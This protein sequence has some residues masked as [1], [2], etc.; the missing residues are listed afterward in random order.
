M[1]GSLFGGNSQK[2][3]IAASFLSIKV[4]FAIPPCTRHPASSVIPDPPHYMERIAISLAGH[5]NL[6]KTTLART[7]LREDI[8]VVDDRPHVTDVADGRVIEKDD[9]A[10]IILWDLPG[11][12]DSVR[13][14]QRLVK[15]GVIAWLMTVYDRW[16]DRP[17][18]CSQKCIENAKND[19]DVV[20]YLVDANADPSSSPEVCAEMDVLGL[21]G[22]PVII[23]LNQTG[24]PDQRRDGQLSS[25]WRRAMRDYPFVHDAMPMDGW[26]RCWIHENMLFARIAPLLTD[27]KRVHYERLIA[28]WKTRH[29]DDVFEEATAILAEALAETASEHAVVDKESIVEK[30]RSVLVRKPSQ[31]VESA[32]AV[33]AGS[34]IARTRRSMERL[35]AVHQLDGISQERVD[36]LIDGLK[37]S[38]PSAPPELLGILGGIGSG[39]LAGLWADLHAGGLSFG[40]GAVAG[41]LLGG[42]AVYA[43]G[44]G[45]K[46]I[47]G[48]DGV[49]RLQWS[50][51][52]MLDEWKA[53]AMRYLM[54]AHFGRGQGQWQEPIPSSWPERWKQFIDE[55]TLRR[56]KDVDAA[57]VSGDSPTIH[58]LLQTMLKDTLSNLY[59][60]YRG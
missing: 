41:G 25:E 38:N 48:E 27:S 3:A 42:L 20:L 59:P 60:E 29:H 13:L 6:G 50:R 51:E 7:L 45:Y 52:F 23:L 9:Q 43:L 33:L 11:F 35:L 37:T 31:Q 47:S 32:R 40:G 12:G 26:M 39:V 36:S 58:R 15:T 4:W 54:V 57:L 19:A 24:L 46:K 10:E 1:S 55:W 49:T 18:W 5:T 8:G 28:A 21:V 44:Y 2:N 14:K 17:L 16:T 53:S 56:K 30:T 34:L 22:K